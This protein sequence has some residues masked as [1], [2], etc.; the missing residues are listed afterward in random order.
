M[1]RRLS[2]L[3][4]ASG[5]SPLAGPSPCTALVAPPTYLK[6]LMLRPPPKH[7]G[8]AS[9]SSE[10]FPPAHNRIYSSDCSAVRAALSD[11]GDG[12]VSPILWPLWLCGPSTPAIGV[13]RLSGHVFRPPFDDEYISA[14][15]TAKCTTCAQNVEIMFKRKKVFERT[16]PARRTLK[17]A[18]KIV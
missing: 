18:S 9:T 13:R 15:A 17:N 3:L 10:W 8:H 1:T 16:K 5:L 7:S 4:P 14:F 11:H 6:T 2:N 12:Q